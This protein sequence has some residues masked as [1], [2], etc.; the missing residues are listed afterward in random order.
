VVTA[1]RL[2][3]GHVIND[4]GLAMLSDFVTD[5]GFDVEFFARLQSETNFVEDAARDPPGFSDARDSREAHARQAANHIQNGWNGRDVRDG[6]D[7]R[8]V[9]QGAADFHFSSHISEYFNV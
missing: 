8:Q 2:I 5:G 6:L 9:A 1:I 3:L 7:I 4:H